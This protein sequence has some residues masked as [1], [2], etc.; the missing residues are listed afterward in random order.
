MIHSSNITPYNWPIVYYFPLVRFVR[1]EVSLSRGLNPMY[2][3]TPPRNA[4]KRP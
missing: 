1:I 3:L 2:G 4:L